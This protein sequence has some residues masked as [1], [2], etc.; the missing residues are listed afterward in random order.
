MDGIFHQKDDRHPHRGHISRHVHLVL[1]Q[2][3][4]SQEDVSIP[5]P[6][7]HIIYGAEV[8]F[9]NPFRH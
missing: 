8:F 6:A 4:D 3:D 5:Q 1:N 9:G 2:L 7:E